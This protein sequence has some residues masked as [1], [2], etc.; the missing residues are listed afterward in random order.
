MSA[1]KIPMQ[2]N[3]TLYICQAHF[4]QIEIQYLFT[5]CCNTSSTFRTE[6]GPDLLRPI[7]GIYKFLQNIIEQSNKVFVAEGT[8]CCIRPLKA[9]CD[10][11]RDN[12]HLQTTNAMQIIGHSDF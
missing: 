4:E 9:I 7:P 1:S 12:Y 10:S 6:S 11:G 2:L 3:Q 5:S 8:E